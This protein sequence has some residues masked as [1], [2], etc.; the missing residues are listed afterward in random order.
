[1]PNTMPDVKMV[2][3]ILIL[4]LVVMVGLWVFRLV[5]KEIPT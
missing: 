4:V 3:G 1:M 2:W 5:K